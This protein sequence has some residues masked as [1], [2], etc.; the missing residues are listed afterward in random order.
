MESS[1]LS[2]QSTPGP[3]ETPRP[4]ILRLALAAAGTVLI[5][6]LLWEGIEQSFAARVETRYLLH[7]VRGISTSLVSALV[8]AWLGYTGHRKQI[9]TLRQEA[10]DRERDA[11]IARTSFET[12]VER[13]PAGLIILDEESRIVYANST[14]HRIHGGEVERGQL[15]ANSVGADH[16]P[17]ASCLAPAVLKTGEARKAKA[18]R[19]D[20]RT[21]EVLKEELYPL[22][23]P[24]GRNYVLVVERIVT[25]QHK[26]QASLVHQEKMAGVGLLAAGIAHD[27]GNPLSAIGMHL[28]LLED[29]LLPQEAK[30]SLDVVRREVSR[31]Q[32]SLRDLVDFARRR[33]GD[34]SWV[35]VREVTQDALTLLRYDKRMRGITVEV[36]FDPD[37]MPVYAV[38]DHLMQV[39][40]NLMINAIDAMSTGGKMKIQ[41]RGGRGQI[42]LRIIDNG[43]GMERKVLERC[44][45]PMFSTKRPGEGTGLGLSMCKDIVQ[46]IGGTLELHSRPNRGTTAIV[47]LPSNKVEHRRTRRSEML[48]PI[49]SDEF[50]AGASRVGMDRPEAIS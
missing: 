41:L 26:L 18:H 2:S 20:P 3:S 22:R 24:D 48:L 44:L 10:Q 8:V 6:F 32:R 35:S 17:C 47:T 16:A 43:V 14:S 19:V 29:E 21:E 30:E 1:F 39:V 40:L 12:V 31:L 37:T 46:G 5:M 42:A 34:E 23:L 15:C 33:G 11:D 36:D 25:E 38:E 50:E 45:E 9:A 13:A 49:L 4:E 27:M 7:Y 28:Q